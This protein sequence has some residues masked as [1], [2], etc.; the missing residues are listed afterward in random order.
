MASANGLVRM[1]AIVSALVACSGSKPESVDEKIARE[2]D[3]TE[4]KQVSASDMGDAYRRNPVDADNDFK[5]RVVRMKVVVNDIT[6]DKDGVPFVSLKSRHGDRAAD[7]V[8]CTFHDR[9]GDVRGLSHGD[10]IT[11]R[12]YVLGEFAGIPVLAACRVER[13]SW[14]EPGKPR[15][16]LTAELPKPPPAPPAD[17]GVEAYVWNG[18]LAPVLKKAGVTYK[19]AW[20]GGGELMIESKQCDKAK[21]A[22]DGIG[23]TPHGYTVLCALPDAKLSEALWRES[24]LY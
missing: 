17:P 5:T 20:I 14:S 24:N 9:P 13:R 15:S 11:V 4:A 23:K 3:T 18:Q 10:E 22:I 12:G 7:D 21:V 2:V 16:A 6:Q 1:A 19:F 8:A